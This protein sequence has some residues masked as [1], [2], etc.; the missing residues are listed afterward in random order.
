MGRKPGIGTAQLTCLNTDTDHSDQ[1]VP[2]LFAPLFL[3]GLLVLDDPVPEFCL[4]RAGVSAGGFRVSLGRLGL[5]HHQPDRLPVFLRAGLRGEPG[6]FLPAGPPTLL[7][8]APDVR[9]VTGLSDWCQ[10]GIDRAALNA[11]PAD[12]LIV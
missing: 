9:S 1:T 3:E 7:L 2:V 4:G 5:P 8:S 11:R 6:R 12:S 10:R